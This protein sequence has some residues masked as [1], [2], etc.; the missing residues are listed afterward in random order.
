MHGYTYARFYICK[1][2]HMQGYTYAYVYRRRRR[3][4]RRRMRRR[5]IG[6]WGKVNGCGRGGGGL[7]ARGGGF[8]C[9]DGSGRSLPR[10]TP[11]PPRRW[12]G[13]GS[14][15]ET[16]IWPRQFRGSF[17]KLPRKCLGQMLIYTISLASFCASFSSFVCCIIFVF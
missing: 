8:Q 17:A 16:N 3:R 11:S 14:F 5:K 4:R 1:V 2:L 15:G 12:L 6:L 7:G 13:R 10:P 9:L